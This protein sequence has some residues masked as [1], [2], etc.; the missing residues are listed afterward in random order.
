M[1]HILPLIG[2]ALV[3]T[4]SP[5][6]ATSL[7]TVSG[8]HHGYA[9]TLPLIAG[10]AAALAGLVAVSGTSLAIA[11][12]AYP[13][14][15]TAVKL[16]G[17]VYL[18][19]LAYRIGFSGPPSGPDQTDH[20]PIGALGGFMLLLLNPK[21]WAM[22]FGVA[23]S[24]STI[25]DDPTHLASLLASVFACAAIFS[26][27]LWALIGAAVAKVLTA[28]WHWHAFNGTMALLLCASIL[29]LWI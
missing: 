25:S 8:A 12:N 15:Q 1:E 6:G 9:K 21:A 24:Y 18:L 14:L 5:G 26:L 16:A 4:L 23:G 10:I 2:F 22:A 11:I 3:A 28:R 20:K 7:A 29:T 27:T 13:F 17:T 19:W